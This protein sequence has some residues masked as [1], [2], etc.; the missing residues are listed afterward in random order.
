[1]IE[2]TEPNIPEGLVEEQLRFLRQGGP[3]PDLTGLD[4]E[5][6]GMAAQA[7]KIIETLVNAAPTSPPLTN[8]PVAIRLGLVGAP[9]GAPRTET[10]DPGDPVTAAVVDV[11]HR[12]SVTALQAAT[13]GT[14]FERRFECRSMVENVLVVAV[15][16]GTSRAAMSAHARGA[17]ALADH[18]SA[19]AYTSAAATN[20]VVL[21]YSDSHEVLNPSSG[22]R[23]AAAGIAGEPLPIALGR[24]FERSDPQW[25]QVERLDASDALAGIDTDAEA[26]VRR[27]KD[28]LT[29]A[30]PRLDFKKDARSFVLEL[31][32]TVLVDWARRVQSEGAN[33]DEILGELRSLTQGSS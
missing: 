22:W 33:A 25:D 9:T 32:D 10:S 15:P 3:E 24:Y 14:A 27:V 18:L 2:E 19:I 16:E 5:A 29:I 7:L 1:M 20:S 17:F 12:F 8:D 30:N 4:V 6:T 13:D 28:T 23:S 31:P 26:I 11:E 21:T